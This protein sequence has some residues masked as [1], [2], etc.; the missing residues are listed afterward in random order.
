MKSVLSPD[1]IHFDIAQCSHPQVHPQGQ[2]Y[3]HLSPERKSKKQRTIFIA[4]GKL[5]FQMFL[6]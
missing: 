3:P 4:A 5:W 1:F 6:E 2:N